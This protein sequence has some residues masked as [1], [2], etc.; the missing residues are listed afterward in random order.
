MDF[1]AEIQDQMKAFKRSQKPRIWQFL[2]LILVAVF[3][4]SAILSG[5]REKANTKKYLEAPALNDVYCV[6][7]DNEYSLMTIAEI[8]GDSIYFM[9]NEYYTTQRLDVKKLHRANFYEKGVIY[10]YSKDELQELYNDKIIHN[11]WRDLAYSTEKLKL[12]DAGVREYSDSE[13]DTE[14]N[15]EDEDE[16][17]TGS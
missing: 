2:G 3:I 13:L 4:G 11:I 12:R 17:E 16:D 14:S 7:E 10:G 8:Q 5:Q 1:P 9:N 6:Q 15:T